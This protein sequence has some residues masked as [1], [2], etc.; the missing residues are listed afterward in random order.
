MDGEHTQRRRGKDKRKDTFAR[1]GKATSRGLR[2]RLALAE[3]AR[4][5]GSDAPR[6]QDRRRRRPGDQ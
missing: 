2:H 5:R 4:A 6:T 3:G 1:Y